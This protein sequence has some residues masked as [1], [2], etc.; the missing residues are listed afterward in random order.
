VLE[1]DDGVPNP[2]LEIVAA[3]EFQTNLKSWVVGHAPVP[4]RLDVVGSYDFATSHRSTT[5]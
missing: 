1:L 5:V 3:R 4:E 2:L